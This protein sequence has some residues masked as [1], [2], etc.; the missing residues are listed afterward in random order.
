MAIYRGSGTT[1]TA[2]AINEL[3][4]YVA[5]AAASASSAAASYDSFDDRYLGVKTSDPSVDNDGNALVAGALY[6]NSTLKTMKVYGGTSWAGIALPTSSALSTG[7]IDCSS[8]SVFSKTI[9]ANTTFSV[10]NVPAAGNVCSFL[11]DLTNGGAYSITWW[12]GVKWAGGVAPSLTS[13]GRDVLAFFTYDGGT[14]W[15]GL[16]LGRDVK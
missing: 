11:L 12:S 16:L 7:A 13:S 8:G 1:G 14:T 5:S 15:T 3:E 2:S 6:Y 4:G 9:S 10:T